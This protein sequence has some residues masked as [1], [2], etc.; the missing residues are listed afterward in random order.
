MDLKGINEAKVYDVAVE[1]PLERAPR[2][3]TRLGNHVW[4]KR[5]D[6]Q[7][8]FSFKLRGAYNKLARLSETERAQGVI[9]ASAGNHAQGVA[10]AAQK[11]GCRAVIV[12]PET[13]PE[14]K[15]SAVRALGAEL[16]LKGDAYPDA[17]LEAQRIAGVEGLLPIHP[18][19]D[20]D[21]IAGQG[22]IGMEILR[23]AHDPPDAIFVAVGGGGMLAGIARYVK[24]LCPGAD[25]IG[26]EP[27]D[28]A[29]MH[30]AL[31]AGRPVELDRVGL[32]ADGVA[33]KRA[34]DLTFEACRDTVREVVLVDTD[35]ICAAIKDVFEDTRS[36]LEPAGALGVAGMKKWVQ[37]EG[38][39]G[40]NLVA[41]ASGAN[42]NFDRLRFVAERSVLGERRE[43][44]MAVTLPEQCG[45]FKAFC[46]FLGARNITEFNYRYADA[47]EAHVFVGIGVRDRVEADQL[48]T[49]LNETGY[50]AVD[51]TD[52]EMAKL[53]LRYMVGGH[54][55]QVTNEVLYRFIFPERPGALMAFLDSL[56]EDWLITLFHY[57]NHGSDAGRV[58][59]ALDVPEADRPAFAASIDALGYQYQEETGNIA[60]K[61]FLGA[62]S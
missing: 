32:F 14:I 31:Q 52:D 33:V 22:T 42:M 23:Q 20:P 2:L 16:V 47:R 10:L 56:S 43:A 17:Q 54:A 5:E 53:H 27:Q 30:E 40:K 59:V 26:V 50:H 60:Y 1:T 39:T 28:S 15:V 37:R 4:L 36:I 9:A 3:S 8:T 34:G 46:H 19:D 55:P 7:S 24:P 48:L 44:V 51:L 11:L 61:M 6:L 12:M 58:L 41:V 49:E 13:T 21:V 62:R 25:I 45:A 38:A 29:A 18:F 35:E 57:R